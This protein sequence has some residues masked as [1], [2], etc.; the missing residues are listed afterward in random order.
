MADGAANVTLTSDDVYSILSASL[1]FSC[2]APKYADLPT[3]DVVQIW[4]DYAREVNNSITP[5]GVTEKFGASPSDAIAILDLAG[6]GESLRGA[7][8]W[9]VE[10]RPFLPHPTNPNVVVPLFIPFTI[11][12]F[13]IMVL[14]LW[15]R[16]KLAGGVQMFDWLAAAGFLMTVAWSALCVYHAH[17]S[18]PYQAYYDQ[19]FNGVRTTAMIYFC[20]MIIYPWIMLVIKASLLL[21]YYRMT[22][23]N[24]IQWSV[25]ATA[26][27][28]VGNTISATVLYLIQYPHVDYWN[29]PFENARLN[30]RTTQTAIAA[31]YILTDVI[32]WVIPMPMVFQLKL[33]PRER[34]LALFTFSLGAVACVASC[35]RLDTLVKFDQYSA[36]S[37][38]YLLID[39]WTMIELYLAIICASAPAIRALAIHYAPKILNS[40]GSAAFSTAATTSTTVAKKTSVDSNTSVNT[41][42]KGDVKTKVTSELDDLEKEVEKEYARAEREAEREAQKEAEREAQEKAE[43]EAAQKEAAQKEAVPQD[44]EKQ[45]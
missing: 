41:D 39:A 4:A 15:S 32:I 20:L 25:Y 21:F 18:S 7:V 45:A 27:I 8:D 1:W 23:W 44:V 16:Y 17:V 30:R 19:T 33:Y 9:M 40:V 13:A 14:R 3:M 28:V 43:R 29:R 42:Q 36:E 12:T 10:S 35:I 34:I 24:Y 31:I 37:S 2:V 5:E 38:T 11:I 26:F 22:R 6:G